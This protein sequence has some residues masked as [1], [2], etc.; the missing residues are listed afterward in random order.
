[1][2]SKTNHV[3]NTLTPYRGKTSTGFRHLET[4]SSL[5]PDQIY[6]YQTIVV[7]NKLAMFIRFYIRFFIIKNSFEKKVFYLLENV[8]RGKL[9]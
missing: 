6:F 4:F 7:L 5:F 8:Q 3:C 1:M 2:V 9:R